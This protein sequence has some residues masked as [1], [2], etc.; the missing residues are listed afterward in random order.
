VQEDMAL[1]AVTNLFNRYKKNYDLLLN[2]KEISFA[3]DYEEQFS[4]VLL[5]ACASYFETN[6]TDLIFEILDINKNKP[7]LI[8]S[9]TLNKALSRQYHTLFNWKDSNINSF[10]GLF[11][12]PF[13]NFV[14]EKIKNDSIFKK[15]TKDFLELG[16]LRNELVHNNYALFNLLLTPQEIETKFESARQFPIKMKILSDEFSI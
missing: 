13:K 16:R 10:L 7:S 2:K 5:L 6:I 1:T 4:K 11:G 8:Y 3:S 9:F 15:S 12:D 14:K